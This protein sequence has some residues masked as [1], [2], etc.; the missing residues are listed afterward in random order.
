[1]LAIKIQH[2]PGTRD[3]DEFQLKVSWA[4]KNLPFSVV[5]TRTWL[6]CRRR[7]VEKK[8]WKNG[9]GEASSFDVVMNYSF[10]QKS[11]HESRN[12]KVTN[13]ALGKTGIAFLTDDWTVAFKLRGSGRTLQRGPPWSQQ[14]LAKSWVDVFVFLCCSFFFFKFTAAITLAALCRLQKHTS[15]RLNLDGTQ[16]RTASVS[17]VIKKWWRWGSQSGSANGPGCVCMSMEVCAGVCV[18]LCMRGGYQ[19][20]RAFCTEQQSVLQ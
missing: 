17:R 13:I 9:F 4:L 14:S 10:S 16:C 2:I 7:K 19:G 12:P 18:C 6:C 1:M 15:T 8:G 11:T 20:R 5:R 3:E